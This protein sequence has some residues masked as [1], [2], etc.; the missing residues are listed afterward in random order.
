MSEIIG[1]EV[2]DRSGGDQYRLVFG[3]SVVSTQGRFGVDLPGP[4]PVSDGLRGYSEELGGFGG[5]DVF[6]VHVPEI[7]QE[8]KE[9]KRTPGSRGGRAPGVL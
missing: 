2:G 9:R 5:G 6:G 4:N 3:D 1:T 7:T 8:S